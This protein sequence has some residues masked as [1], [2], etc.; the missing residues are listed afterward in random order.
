MNV[1]LFKPGEPPRAMELDGSLSAMQAVVGGRIQAVYPFPEPVA[2]ICNDEGKLLHLP[3]NR[4]LL[5]DL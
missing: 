5:L 2:L 4:C 1:L 3:P